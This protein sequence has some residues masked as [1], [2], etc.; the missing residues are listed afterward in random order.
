MMTGLFVTTIL[1]LFFVF[2]LLRAAPTAHGDSQARGLIGAVAAS[3]YQSHS[4]TRS[5]PHLR[6]HH[7]SLQHRIFNPLSEAW[8][9]T[10]NLMVPS[11]IHFRWA[12]TRT[13][14][15]TILWNWKK[16]SSF[17]FWERM[18]RMGKNPS[19]IIV[20]PY[21]WIPALSLTNWLIG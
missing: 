6:P 13:L 2:C 16:H 10:R 14:V 8:E 9:W 18:D 12:T 5:E 19:F 7:S 17:V 15:T 1:L 3:L 11:W 21:F 4:N 20:W